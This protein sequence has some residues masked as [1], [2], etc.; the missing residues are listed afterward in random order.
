[1]GGRVVVPFLLLALF[2]FGARPS[3]AQVPGLAMP[4]PASS[5][6]AAGVKREGI[7]LTAPISIDGAVVFR[8]ATLQTSGQQLKVDTRVDLIEGALATILAQEGNQPGA[9][10]IYD[11]ETLRVKVQSASGLPV[12]V[13]YD[14]HHPEPLAI[15]TVTEADA[16]VNRQPL[17]LLAQAWRDKLER[18]LVAALENRQ[19]T[20]VRQNIRDVLIV[21]AGVLL[22]SVALVAVLVRL[23]RRMRRIRDGEPAA[24]TD[25]ATLAL[26]NAER[27]RRLTVAKAIAACLVWLLVLLWFAATIWGL[28]LF[29]ATAALGRQTLKTVGTVAFI[30]IVAG[31]VN[32]IIDVVTLRF[33]TIYG[34]ED[35]RRALRIP[36]ITK[37][38]LGFKTFVLVFTAVLATLSVLGFPVASVV[39]IGG[40][41]ALT[42]T[43]AAQNLLR[44]W[45][46][47]FLVLLEDQYIVNDRVIIAGCEGVVEH[48]TLRV[49]QIRDDAGKLTT[50]PHSSAGQVV[51][52]SRPAG[53]PSQEAPV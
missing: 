19:P 34:Q 47:G 40:I 28:L 52:C 37:A 22:V 35:T 9:P 50:I 6:L 38:V 48:L 1:M 44:D 8:V 2:A 20:R 11:P 4:S 33:E 10:T 13:A 18:S 14:A 7:Y 43:F 31:L 46:N 53:K 49:V 3:V 23:H 26:R 39:T 16:G 12:L 32:R 27:E 29:P 5:G 51:N 15:L 30:W 25:D 21:W 45:L 17:E 36:T 42:V 41:A 24:S